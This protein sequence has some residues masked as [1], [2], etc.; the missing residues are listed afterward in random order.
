MAPGT[1][2]PTPPL[3]AGG[4]LVH[5]GSNVLAQRPSHLDILYCETSDTGTDL[6]REM[7]KAPQSQMSGASCRDGQDLTQRKP[8]CWYQAPASASYLAGEACKQCLNDGESRGAAC[9]PGNLVSSFILSHSRCP[10]HRYP[11]PPP[12]PPSRHGLA[13]QSQGSGIIQASGKESLEKETK[14]T[15]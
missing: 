14:C 8:V 13:S 9:S 15:Q 4:F 12:P 5:L 7:G 1:L 2:S 6:G 10:P 3:R 11:P